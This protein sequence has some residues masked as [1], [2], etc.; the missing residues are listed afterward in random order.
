MKKDISLT[1][2]LLAKK[3]VPWEL[4]T[5]ILTQYGEKKEQEGHGNK[6]GIQ[7]NVFE[8]LNLCYPVSNRKS[9]YPGIVC[10]PAYQTERAAL[11]DI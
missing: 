10:P 5:E 2:V 1:P 4:T 8:H 3:T 9:S 7:A 6:Q 11:L